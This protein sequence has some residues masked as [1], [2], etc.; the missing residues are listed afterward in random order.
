M[1]AK[2]CTCCAASSG[3]LQASSKI[4]ASGAPILD[5]DKRVLQ[6]G[7]NSKIEDVYT[8]DSSR[9]GI[10]SRSAS[11]SVIK[12]LRKKEKTAVAVKKLSKKSFKGQWWTTDI[13][14]MK[15]LDNPHICRIFE[16]WED[17]EHVYIVMEYC[18]GGDLTSLHERQDVDHSEA[19]VAVLVRQMVGAVEHFHECGSKERPLVHT[20]IRLENWLFAEPPNQQAGVSQMCLKMIDFGLAFRHALVKGKHHRHNEDEQLHQTKVGVRDA[21]SAFCRAPEQL[22]DKMCERLHPGM[23]IWAIGVIAFFLLSGKPPFPRVAGNTNGERVR[24]GEY[25]FE[26][27]SSWKSVSQQAKD[28]VKKCLQVDPDMRPSGTEL[29]QSAWMVKAKDFFNRDLQ[30]L[31][32]EKEAGGEHARLPAA[33]DL[34]KAFSHMHKLN[35][36]ERCAITAAAHRLPN[37]KID[38]LRQSFEKM[39]KNGDGVLSP[40]E[41]YEALKVSGVDEAALLDMLAHVDSDGSGVI[42][43]TEFIAA[44]WDFQRTLQSDISW[45]VFKIFDTDQSGTVT[46]KEILDFLGSGSNKEPLEEQFPDTL[47]DAIL[48]LDKDKDGT[49]DFEEFKKLL[50]GSHRQ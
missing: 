33:G 8:F 3:S 13:E 37:G 14:S 48:A 36:L 42:E 38:Y 10:I 17:S 34:V 31:P 46:K 20:D 41:L 15:K 45:S 19:T 18:Q 43:Y 24:S 26:P 39:D 29:L 16:V 21:R 27:E 35:A 22:S 6:Y 25:K 9:K 40:K 2:A 7:E 44:A 5:R 47:H 11:G 32:G 50:K 30:A 23:D 12:A 4:R 28:F 49:I 1:G